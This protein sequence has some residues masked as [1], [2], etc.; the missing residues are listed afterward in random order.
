VR[1]ALALWDAG[2]KTSG[3]CH[4]TSDGFANLSRLDA[5]VGY[6]IEELPPVP[7]IFE[8]IQRK[9]DIDDAEMYRVFNMGVGFVVIVA[10]DDETNAIDKINDAGY[11]AQRIGT[12]TDEEGTVTI[13]PVGLVG[14]LHHGESGFQTL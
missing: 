13:R 9:G 5:P 4:V 12:V 8:L 6:D 11:R 1:A 7:K 10:P 3:L 14:G 2:I